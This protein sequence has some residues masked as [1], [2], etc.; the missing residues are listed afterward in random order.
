M[1]RMQATDGH[2]ASAELPVVAIVKPFLSAPAYIELDAL[3]RLLREPGRV[4]AAYL[5]IDRRQREAFSAR[6]K[7]LPRIVVGEF[8]GQRP[9]LDAQA[10]QPGQ[11]LLRHRCS[12]CSR[13]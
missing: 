11:R 1:V 6:A 4:T 5:L 9:G 3:N 10:A 7:E 13:R 2:R 12:S 8:P